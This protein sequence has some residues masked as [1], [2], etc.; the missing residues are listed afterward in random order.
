M[1]PVVGH[2]HENCTNG[3]IFGMPGP[4]PKKG[5]GMMAQERK[6][7][8]RVHLY[9]P[10]HKGQRRNLSAISLAA[11]ALDLDDREAVDGLHGAVVSLRDEMRVHASLE[12]KFIHPMLSGR[13]PGA[14]RSL[15]EDHASMHRQL[16][17]LHGHFER[18]RSEP[19]DRAS[20]QAMVLEFYRA[21]NRFISFYLAHID[22]EEESVQVTL[23]AH[24]SDEVLSAAYGRMIAALK[25]AELMLNLGHMLPAMDPAEREAILGMAKAAMPPAAFAAVTE[26]AGKVLAPGDMAALRERLGI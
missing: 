22:K 15:E 5:G 2:T 25:P 4:G 10:V 20:R 11:G 19:Q 7:Q 1:K 13:I 16:D 26:L 24:Y 8:T 17:E 3:L 12:E 18:V 14:A 9:T 21:M 6:A 23:W